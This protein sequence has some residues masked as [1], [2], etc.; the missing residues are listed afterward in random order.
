M[1]NPLNKRFIRELKSDLGRYIVLFVF[2]V[3]MIAIVSGFQVAGNSMI[4]AYDESF[5]KYNIED[6]NFELTAKA[7]EELI[8]KIEENDVTIYENFYLEEETTSTKCGASCAQRPS[9]RESGCNPTPFHKR[10]PPFRGAE[11]RFVYFRIT[12]LPIL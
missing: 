5:E 2:I 8:S 7:D 4:K 11:W 6:G 9:L 1:K 12:F 10:K 3:A